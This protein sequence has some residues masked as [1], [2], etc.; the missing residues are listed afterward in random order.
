MVQKDTVEPELFLLLKDLTR[1]PF[2]RDFALVGGTALSLQVGHRK[3][4]DIDFFSTAPFDVEDLKAALI[5][6]YN[7]M[8]SQQLSNC[9]MGYIQHIK[10][11]FI[12]HQYKLVKPLIEEAGIRMVSLED[13]AAMKLNAIMGSGKRLKDFVDIAFLSARFTLAE[14]LAF[15]EEKYPNNNAVMAYK[16]LTWL[17]DIDFSSGILYT[18]PVTWQKIQ[19]RVL[20]MVRHP[21][22]NFGMLS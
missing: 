9:L 14:M 6:E 2:L 21:E 1:Q 20:E 18:K 10:T 12:S 8:M 15:F 22:R 13:I 16:S 5:K 11:D 7:F 4:I 19:Q 17:E 3:S